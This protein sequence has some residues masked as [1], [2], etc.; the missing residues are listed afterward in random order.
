MFVL[1]LYNM[2]RLQMLLCRDEINVSRLIGASDSFIMRPL[3]YYAILQVLIASGVAY[4]LVNLFINFI[5]G[6]FRHLNY[7]FGNSFL[8]SNLDKMD[9]VQMLCILIIFT[10]FSVFLAVRWIFK[11]SYSQ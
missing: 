1:V 5:N 11:N 10:I 8:L 7:L 2:I 9:L 6:L 4:L 3:A